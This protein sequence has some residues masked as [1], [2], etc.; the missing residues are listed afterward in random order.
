MADDAAGA[1]AKFSATAFMDDNILYHSLRL[2][3]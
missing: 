3:S 2:M 1:Q